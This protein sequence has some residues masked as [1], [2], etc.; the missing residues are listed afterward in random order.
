ML[1]LLNNTKSTACFP[2]LA[3]KGSKECHH[4]YLFKGISTFGLLLHPFAQRTQASLVNTR[5]E[6]A[7]KKL[8]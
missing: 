6:N 1:D 7:S 2:I 4:L 5:V 8:N 3:Q